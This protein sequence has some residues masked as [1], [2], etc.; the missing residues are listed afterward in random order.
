MKKKQQESAKV[1]LINSQAAAT[2][3][4]IDG[5]TLRRK[6]RSGRIPAEMVNGRWMFNPARITNGEW[7]GTAA[8][9]IGA[10]LREKASFV[11]PT[12][13]T[14]RKMVQRKKMQNSLPDADPPPPGK[15]WMEFWV[16]GEKKRVLVNRRPKKRNQ[17]A[18]EVRDSIPLRRAKIVASVKRAREG[19]Q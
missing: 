5:V 12:S 3:L 7:D 10:G 11:Q 1:E 16:G 13:R 14:E 8:L 6:V 18:P 15:R 9:P 19:A 4:G 17:Q 2:L